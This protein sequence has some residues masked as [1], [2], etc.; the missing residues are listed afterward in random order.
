MQTLAGGQAD[1]FKTLQSSYAT[2]FGEQQGVLSS[3]TN[4]LDPILKAGPN[5][6]GFSASETADLRGQAINTNAAQARNAQVIAAS[7]AG[8]NT[9]VT[10]GGQKQLQAE[11]ASRAGTSLSS[12][13]N[14]INLKSAEV[15]RENFFTAESG[16]AGVASL[17]NPNP[18]AGATTSAGGQAYSDASVNNQASNQW[19][20]DLG[21]LAGAALGGWASG[22]FKT[23]P[24]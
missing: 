7:S 24:A 11:I 4:A 8:G 14:Q 12:E 20:A 5:Q 19:A 13:E 23:K 17:E 2:N 21:G 18:T 1:F 10:T 3:I 15:G 6:M 16:L 9:G 22:G